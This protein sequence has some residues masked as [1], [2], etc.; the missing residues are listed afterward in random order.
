MEKMISLG[1][2]LASVSLAFL[3]RLAALIKDQQLPNLPIEKSRG[4]L[5]L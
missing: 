3:F 2:P 5:E 1:P 4:P